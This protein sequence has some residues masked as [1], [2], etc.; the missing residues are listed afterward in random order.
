MRGLDPSKIEINI[1]VNH[2]LTFLLSAKHISP[3]GPSHCLRYAA[4]PNTRKAHAVM[5]AAG[6]PAFAQYEQNRLIYQRTDTKQN[7]Y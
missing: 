4:P 6:F 7:V 1:Y 5:T 2:M 3:S